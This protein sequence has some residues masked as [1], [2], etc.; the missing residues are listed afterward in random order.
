MIRL[1]RVLLV[2]LSSSQTNKSFYTE[3]QG[4]PTR[5]H[6]AKSHRQQRYVQQGVPRRER[7][8]FLCW[9]CDGPVPPATRQARVCAAQRSNESPSGA[10]K[11]PNG[12][13]QQDGGALPRQVLRLP[14]RMRPPRLC[15]GIKHTKSEILA[16]YAPQISSF[17]LLSL[18]SPGAYLPFPGGCGA[19]KRPSGR[20]R[21]QDAPQEGACIPSM[22]PKK[23]TQKGIF[24]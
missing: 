8:V 11:R 2:E 14:G 6:P 16:P 20:E 3:K 7:S 19:T 5:T 15:C 13:A 1:C 17:D 24:A 4:A 22:R 10:F 23:S 12:L 9:G 18:F 21:N